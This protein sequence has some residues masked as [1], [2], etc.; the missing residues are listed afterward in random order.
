MQVFIHFVHI[1]GFF[2]IKKIYCH[3]QH[4]LIAKYKLTKMEQLVLKH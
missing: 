2:Y 3:K 1:L 4:F